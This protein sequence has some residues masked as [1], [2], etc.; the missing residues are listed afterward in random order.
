VTLEHPLQLPQKHARGA[1]PSAAHFICDLLVALV[2][3]CTNQYWIITQYQL[4][5][6]RGM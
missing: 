6:P 5:A 4:C 3:Y 1:E 2:E